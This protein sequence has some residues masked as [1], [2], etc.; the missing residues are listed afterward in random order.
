MLMVGITIVN[1]VYLVHI[2]ASF[3]EIY[4]HQWYLIELT[5]I[6]DHDQ[7]PCPIAKGSSL[8]PSHIKLCTTF[9][10]KLQMFPLKALVGKTFTSTK[11]ISKYECKMI[12]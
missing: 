11:V 5:V 8:K 4:L 1:I 12:Q 3:N 2:Q 6:S 9:N 10:I 7:E